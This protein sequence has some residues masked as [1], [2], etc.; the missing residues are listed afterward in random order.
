M[1]L[2]LGQDYKASVH[3]GRSVPLSDVTQ[4]SNRAIVGQYQM[5]IT[6]YHDWNDDKA[7][8][9][10][11]LRINVTETD[12]KSIYSGGANGICRIFVS[13]HNVTTDG[14]TGLKH[15][16]NSYKALIIISRQSRFAPSDQFIQTLP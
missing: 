2:Y 11:T 3:V 12:G 9:S 8:P 13:V 6:T 15:I 16:V 7:R 10:V 4:Q 14:S 5:V 1:I